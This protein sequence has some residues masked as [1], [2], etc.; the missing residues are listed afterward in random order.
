MTRSGL[1]TWIV[2]RRALL[3]VVGLASCLL[4]GL[5]ALPAAASEMEDF[6]GGAY[7]IL[8]PG[9]EGSIT[10]GPYSRDQ[11]VLYEKLTPKGGKVTQKLLEKD[12]LSEKFGVHTKTTLRTETTPRGANVKIVRD[13][14]DIPHVT[15]LTRGDVMYGSGWIAGKD[16]G[17]LLRLGLG[18]AYTAALGIPGINAFGLLLQQRSF[19][20][21]AEAIEFVK[22]QIVTLEEKGAEGLQVIEDLEN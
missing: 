1:G 19:K 4:F 14:N 5:T 2:R 11:K 8:P 15:G 6:S 10:Q 20:P 3:V 7:Q 17:L 12:F 13:A 22:N 9:D 16:R 18:P 21:S